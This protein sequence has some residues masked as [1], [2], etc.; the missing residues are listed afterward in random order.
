MK[1]LYVE[2]DID[3]RMVLTDFLRELGEFDIAVSGKEAL[4]A[5]YAAYD[6]GH[7]YDLILLDVMIPEPDGQAVLRTLRDFERERKMEPV[8][9]IMITALADEES[10]KKAF[11]GGC[12]GYLRKPFSKATFFAEVRKAGLNIDSD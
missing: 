8:K 1:V 11:Y 5:F 10:V 9:I 3:T 4:R 12:S 7:P 2:D 6:A